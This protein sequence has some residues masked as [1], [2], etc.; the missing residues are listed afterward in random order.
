[1]APSALALTLPFTFGRRA[2]LH[3]ILSVPCRFLS[4]RTLSNFFSPDFS[5]LQLLVFVSSSS[6]SE[7]SLTPTRA[8][9]N[10]KRQ[11]MHMGGQAGGEATGVRPEGATKWSRAWESEEEAS[12]N[13]HTADLP[14]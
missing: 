7:P 11:S 8:N 10:E 9:S 13:V 6:F 1:M 14:A 2:S 4:R 12:S 5:F 3:E